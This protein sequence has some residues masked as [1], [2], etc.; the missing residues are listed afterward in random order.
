MWKSGENGDCFETGMGLIRIIV[1][2]LLAAAIFG[3]AGWLG[4]RL[5]LEP[6][7]AMEAERQAATRE[8]ETQAA[9]PDPVETEFAAV[10]SQASTAAPAAAREMWA[11]FL[12][13]HP[14]SP[15]AAEVRAL[16][17]PLNMQA[18]FAPGGEATQSTHTVAGGDSL[19]RVA[20]TNKTT[21]ELIARA[22]NL[23]NTMLRIGQQLV[24][25]KV[26]ISIV[27]D[28]A[29]GVIRL[30]NQGTFLREYKLLA[31]PPPSLAA[32][33]A[34]VADLVVETD[35]KRLTFGQ[36]GYAEGRR[37]IVISSGAVINGAPADTP[38][39]A[40]PA[41]FVVKDEDLADIFVLLRRGDPVTIL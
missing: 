4:Y 26:E 5:Y 18:L 28:R 10:S 27:L 34:R 7:M 11:G 36:K 35:G 32:G 2:L 3:G 33:A 9:A 16:L 22:N 6:K 38:A 31:P 29:G 12:A 15:R 37:S 1:V 40:L 13:K 21:I 39:A 25:P 8:T 23:T 19:Y 14:D 30:Q 41:G 20:K 24:V 17:G